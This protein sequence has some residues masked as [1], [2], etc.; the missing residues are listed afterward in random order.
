MCWNTEADQVLAVE[1]PAAATQSTE[2]HFRGQSKSS[3]RGM[4]IIPGI[5]LWHVHG[6]QDKCY[7]RCREQRLPL[8]DM[9]LFTREYMTRTCSTTLGAICS[10]SYMRRSFPA[11]CA[12]CAHTS[13]TSQC[14]R[15]P[16]L[17]CPIA[18]AIQKHPSTVHQAL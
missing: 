9:A 4:D 15:F 1:T 16:T 18:P 11:Q 2:P 7:V 6:Y 3:P 17:E 8:C 5:G 10:Y 13:R 12:P 14:V